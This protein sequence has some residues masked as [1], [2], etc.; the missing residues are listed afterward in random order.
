MIK[1]STYVWLAMVNGDRENIFMCSIMLSLLRVST[2]ESMIPRPYFL[3]IEIS[4]TS[5]F[6]TCLLVAIFYFRLQLPLIIIHIT[7]IS[8]SLHRTSVPIYLT[9]VLGVGDT[10]DFLYLNCMVA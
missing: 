8:L 5:S 9:S 10:R 3:S 1:R 7:C 6:A 4:F 2:S